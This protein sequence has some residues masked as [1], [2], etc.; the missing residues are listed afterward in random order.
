MSTFLAG[1]ASS[2]VRRRMCRMFGR[3]SQVMSLAVIGMSHMGH[4]CQHRYTN[5]AITNLLILVILYA[6]YGLPLILVMMTL[7]SYCTRMYQ[8][9]LEREL[10]AII[11]EDLSRCDSASRIFSC[12]VEMMS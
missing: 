12:F 3:M 1:N 5:V 6:G 4:I 9:P 10:V 2:E 7:R 11:V 8:F